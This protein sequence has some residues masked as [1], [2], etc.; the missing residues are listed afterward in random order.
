MTCPHSTLKHNSAPLKCFASQVPESDLAFIAGD[1]LE[2]IFN[3]EVLECGLSV[4]LMDLGSFC[5]II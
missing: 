4:Y 3:V 5:Q 1:F 2:T